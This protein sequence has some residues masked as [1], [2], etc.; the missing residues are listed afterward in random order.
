MTTSPANPSPPVI[1]MRDVMVNSMKDQSVT[2]AGNIDWTVAAGEFWLVA[3]TQRSGKTD[4]LMLTGGLMS[5]AHGTY[6]LFGEEMPIF[7]EERLA[8]RLRIGFVFADGHLFNQMTV[9]E[10][11]GLSLRYHENLAREAAES[12]VRAMLELTELTAFANSTPG[13]VSRNW[14]KRAGLA[15][16][17]MLRPEVLLLDDPLAGL[18]ARHSAWLLRFLDQ[19]SQGHALLQGKPM[20]IVATTDNLSNSAGW[21]GHA[22]RVACLIEKRLQVFRDWPELDGCRTATV[23]DLLDVE[24]SDN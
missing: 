1:E 5:P 3:G 23:R 8:E 10:N 21:R 18:D 2:V 11:V 7:E 20:T 17:L 16:A 22:R 4:F 12:R 19:L 13:S 6:R 14:L 9:A 15:R 24:P